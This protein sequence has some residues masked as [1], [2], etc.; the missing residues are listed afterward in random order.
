MNSEIAIYVDDSAIYSGSDKIENV[1]KNIKTY[2]DK[3]QK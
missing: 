1:T 2:L 3:F